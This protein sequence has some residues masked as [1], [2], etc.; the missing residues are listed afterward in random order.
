MFLGLIKI[1]YKISLTSGMFPPSCDPC[2]PG[3]FPFPNQGFSSLIPIIPGLFPLCGHGLELDLPGISGIPVPSQGLCSGNPDIPGLL[4]IPCHGFCSG[5]PG[6]SGLFTVLGLLPGHSTVG[7]ISCPGLPCIPGLLFPGIAMSTT[8]CHPF[9]RRPHG[10]GF[11]GYSSQGFFTWE[12]K[13]KLTHEWSGTSKLPQVRASPDCHLSL[14]AFL[15]HE[16]DLCCICGFPKRMRSP[17]IEMMH[18]EISPWTPC[19]N[20]EMIKSWSNPDS[21][22]NLIHYF[23]WNSYLF[24]LIAHWNQVSKILTVSLTEADSLLVSKHWPL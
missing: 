10:F 18:R 3:L 4:P 17:E 5:N 13:K 23:F 1:R 8:V 24:S 16:D 6:C 9:G 14:W 20:L 21:T 7:S 11:G 19:H 12:K 15:A 2:I 22:K